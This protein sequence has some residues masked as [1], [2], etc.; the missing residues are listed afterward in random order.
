MA[1]GVEIRLPFLDPR[2]AE[3]A[4]SLPP[5]LVWSGGFTKRVLR[6]AMRGLV[7]DEVLDRRD[8]VGFE[9]PEHQWFGSEA[10]RDLVAETLLD[11]T[12]DAHV[13]RAEIERDLAHGA[14]RDTAAIWRAV[15]VRL[16]RAAVRG[17]VTA[18][19]PPLR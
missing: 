9:T 6:D 3:F 7:P 13:V 8:K 14:W 19:P 10:G 1:S 16:W 15:N 11:E 12:A 17:P 18:S 5:E 4:L 2:V